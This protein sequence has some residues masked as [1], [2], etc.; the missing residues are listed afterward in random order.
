MIVDQNTTERI[1]SE[2]YDLLI[3]ALGFESRASYFARNFSI[4]AQKKVAISFEFNKVLAYE[5]NKDFF[6]NNGFDI[7]HIRDEEIGEYL[8]SLVSDLTSELQLKILLD[9]SSL[10]RSKIARI[11][12]H[13]HSLSRTINITLDIV[14]CTAVFSEPDDEN[15]TIKVSS[16]ISSYF[17]GWP[18]DPTYPVST[19]IGLGYDAGKA[20]GAIEYL[21]AGEYWLL[22]PH[23]FDDKFLDEVNKANSDLLASTPDSNIID[24]RLNDPVTLYLT[25]NSLI[26]GAKETSR[27]IIIPFGPKIFA[28][29]SILVAINQYPE[30]G[31]WRVSSDDLETPVDRQGDGNV[32][33]IRVILNTQSV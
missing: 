16:Y 15:S 23:G 8:S 2:S 25:L 7:A 6:A 13:F 17:A 4:N 19:I 14:Y 24:Y 27:P 28:V 22:K 18:I 9:C 31:I 12:Q 26:G 5:E 1:C 3:C 10:S 32:S 21:E 11:A 30:I 20:M 33:C 29:C